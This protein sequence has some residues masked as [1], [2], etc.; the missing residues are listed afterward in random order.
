MPP[1]ETGWDPQSRASSQYRLSVCSADE[2]TRL[3]VGPRIDRSAGRAWFEVLLL[4]GAHPTARMY[5]C[6]RVRL[7]L[8]GNESMQEWTLHCLCC[9]AGII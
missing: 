8:A 2:R 5:A 7:W 1:Y 6:V 4:D 3:R 9:M